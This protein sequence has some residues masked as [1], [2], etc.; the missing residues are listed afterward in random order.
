MLHFLKRYVQNKSRV[1]MKTPFYE[2]EPLR[3]NDYRP[4]TAAPREY[5]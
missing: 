4:F 1:S 2:T 5:E 3:E